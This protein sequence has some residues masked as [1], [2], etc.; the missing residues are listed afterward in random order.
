MCYMA[1]EET[2]EFQFSLP[3]VLYYIMFR[4]MIRIGEMFMNVIQRDRIT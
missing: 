1:A 2:A 4:K 3:P